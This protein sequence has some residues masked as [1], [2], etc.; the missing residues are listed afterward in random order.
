M[1]KLAKKRIILWFLLAVLLIWDVF[2]LINASK[3]E[4]HT[5]ID[6]LGYWASGRLFWEGANPYDPEALF[7]V[8]KSAGFF[9]TRGCISLSE[10]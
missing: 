9:E 1:P 10:M 7:V 5:G 3:A 8:E 4:V 6:F 2:S